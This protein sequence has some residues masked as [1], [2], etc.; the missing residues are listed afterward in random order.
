MDI[1]SSTL[2][3]S[4]KWLFIGLIY[5]V[6]FV[7]LIAVR[8]EM[9]LQAPVKLQTPSAAAG[10]LKIIETGSDSRF[11]PGAVLGLQNET[12]I[13]AD[14]SNNLVLADRFVSARHAHLR[15]DGAGWWLEDLGSKNGTSVNRRLLPAHR[16]Q[17]VPFGATL[18]IGD[19]VFELVE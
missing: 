13:G 4:A 16:E 10:R 11:R 18:A 12:T 19:M 3:F 6:L 7:V 9:H 15:W 1:F 17:S 14:R 2:L 8:R 5:L